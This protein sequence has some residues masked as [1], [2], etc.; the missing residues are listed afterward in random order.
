MTQRTPS[1]CGRSRRTWWASAS[2]WAR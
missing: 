2:R 1:F